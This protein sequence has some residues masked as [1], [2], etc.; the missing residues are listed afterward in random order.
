MICSSREQWIDN[1]SLRNKFT[2]Q[3]DGT[4]AKVL[5][6]VKSN[7]YCGIKLIAGFLEYVAMKSQVYK[8]SY[9]TVVL[10][11]RDQYEIIGLCKISHSIKQPCGSICLKRV[12]NASN[13]LKKCST[14]AKQSGKSNIPIYSKL[15]KI[16][17]LPKFRLPNCRTAVRPGYTRCRPPD[18]SQVMYSRAKF[19]KILI[20]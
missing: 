12:S 8:I 17:A 10:Y 20:H 16:Q 19:T 5:S 6:Q 9:S 14:L 15:L 2:H 11:S 1:V 3:K 4:S 18:L 7:V 13:L